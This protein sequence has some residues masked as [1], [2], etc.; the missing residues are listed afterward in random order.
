MYVADGDGTEVWTL[1]D[2]KLQSVWKNG[3]P[4]TSPVISG[5]L[6]YVYNPKGGLLV[7]EP[8]TGKQIANLDAGAGH[9][10]SPIIVDGR[11]ALPEGS[12]NDHATS[13][14]LDIWRVK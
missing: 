3:N 13:G 6:L 5:G 11:I 14:V 1:S 7:Y 8:S 4:G 12:A 2:G 10:N 9:W